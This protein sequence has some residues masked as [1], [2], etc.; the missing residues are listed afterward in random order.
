MLDLLQIL[1]L[2]EIQ[3][4]EAMA[5]TGYSVIDGIQ[6]VSGETVASI[7]ETLA[8]ALGSLNS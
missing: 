8:E 3:E 5:D 6:S 1:D 7:K 4:L 2:E